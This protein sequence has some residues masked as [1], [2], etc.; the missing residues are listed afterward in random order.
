MHCKLL[1]VVVILDSFLF[2]GKI[3]ISGKGRKGL[4]QNNKKQAKAVSAHTQGESL[5]VCLVSA[6]GWWNQPYRTAFGRILSIQTQDSGFL[7]FTR[8]QR[9]VGSTEPTATFET[10]HNSGTPPRRSPLFTDLL[11]ASPSSTFITY[12]KTRTETQSTRRSN[13]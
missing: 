3:C 2:H 11:S 6:T 1:I 8:N 4:D 10:L 13:A 7:S 5:A 12:D 9:I